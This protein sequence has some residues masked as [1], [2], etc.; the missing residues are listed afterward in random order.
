MITPGMTRAEILK[1]VSE[2]SLE[3]GGAYPNKSSIMDWGV[4]PICL[5]DTL[6][7]KHGRCAYTCGRNE[8]DVRWKEKHGE[9]SST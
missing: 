3:M 6:F 2:F 1:F 8:C 4:C 5:K 7:A 9:M